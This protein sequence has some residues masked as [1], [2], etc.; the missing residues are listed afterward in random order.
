MTTVYDSPTGITLGKSLT[1]L[2]FGVGT[3]AAESE[4]AKTIES[5]IKRV[6]WVSFFTG[7]SWKIFL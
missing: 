3:V 7:I 6:V 5:A 4:A 1:S 2:N